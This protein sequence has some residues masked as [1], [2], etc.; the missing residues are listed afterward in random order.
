VQTRFIVAG[1]CRYDST[2]GDRGSTLWVLRNK[3]A[4]FVE[5]VVRLTQTGAELEIFSD[6][7]SV[8]F[9]RFGSGAE[10]LA[11]ATDVRELWSN[12]DG[13]DATTVMRQPN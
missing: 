4:R 11:W 1:S 3:R 8:L 2:V 7:S 6:G 12:D 9:H 10:A 5:C 13:S